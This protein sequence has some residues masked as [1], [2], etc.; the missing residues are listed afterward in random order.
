[1]LRW[2]VLFLDFGFS[3]IFFSGLVLKI[4]CGSSLYVV[5]EFFEGK[6]YYVLGVD[7]WVIIKF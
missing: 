2:F 4:W 3:N 5:F 7:V 1:M 6:E